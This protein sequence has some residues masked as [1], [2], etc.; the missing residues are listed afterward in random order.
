LCFAVFGIVG[1]RIGWT[2]KESLTV[3]PTALFAWT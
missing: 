3:R 2:G 1:C